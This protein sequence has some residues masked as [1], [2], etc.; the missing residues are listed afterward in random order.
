MLHFHLVAFTN[1][2][3]YVINPLYHQFTLSSIHFII[4]SLYH[5]SN[6]IINPERRLQLKTQRDD[7]TIYDPNNVIANGFINLLR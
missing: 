7:T 5:Q 2:Q 4:N 3:N 1:L 6:F